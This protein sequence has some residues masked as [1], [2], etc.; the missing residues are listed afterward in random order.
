MVLRSWCNLSLKFCHFHYL[1]NLELVL[2]NLSWSKQMQ[3]AFLTYHISRMRAH[4]RI[5]RTQKW[6]K[7]WISNDSHF[8]WESFF[9]RNFCCKSF[10]TNSLSIAGNSRALWRR[11]DPCFCP[12]E[13]TC[14][15]SKNSSTIVSNLKQ[16]KAL[17]LNVFE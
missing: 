16:L 9:W 10:L 5:T 1:N 15:V 7:R 17:Q 11:S 13:K 6:M 8:W 14:K 4:W 2:D 3:D 12:T